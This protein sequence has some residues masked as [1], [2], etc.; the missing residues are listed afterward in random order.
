MSNKT[1]PLSLQK[2]M[3]FWAGAL[4]LLVAALYFF[5]PILLPFV[6]G[7]AVAYLLNPIVC[8]LEDKGLPRR[9][10]VLV[11]LAAFLFFALGMLAAALPI[12][13]REISE[14][15]ENVPAY[16]DQLWIWV[17]PYS[18]RIE[19]AINRRSGEDLGA[20]LQEHA[21][22]ALNVAESILGG[23]AAG[24]QALLGMLS[25]IIVMP[26]VAYFFMQEW[27][28]IE[29]W[30]TDLLPRDHKN[31]ILELLGEMNTKISGFVRGQLMVAFVLAVVYA[32]AL[33]LM[34]LKYGFLIGVGAGLL[35]IIPL[36]GSTVGM[37]VAV[38]VA[39]VQGGDW[40]FILSVA[41]VFLAGQ[42]I[43]GNFLTPKLVGK[44]VGLH[45]LWVFFALMA[46]GALGGIVGIMLAVP[47]AAVVG[48]LITFALRQYK[49][50]PYYKGSKTSTAQK[51][52]KK[53]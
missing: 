38:L 23:L 26:I 53:K 35:N 34:G 21:G 43:E 27:R 41:G 29:Q 47:V 8:W 20:L 16:M 22:S 9:I 15:S 18:L 6:A 14:F 33:S 13:I 2:Q 28:S 37:L 12:L 36:V 3:W 24:G 31:T 25:L 51:K 1:L 48:V 4:L 17:E 40:V 45:P 5:Q 32:L 42:L 30:G 7:A 44:S 11:L 10:G 52:K 39:W 50:S 19:E 46:G 49:A